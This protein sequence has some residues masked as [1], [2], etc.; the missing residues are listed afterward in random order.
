MRRDVNRRGFTLIELLVVMGIVLVLAGMLLT[1]ISAA[2]KYVARART[3]A[4]IDSLGL[5]LGAY[6][7]EFGSFPPGGLDS[8]EDGDCDDGGENTGAG[9]PGNTV[10]LMKLRAVCEELQF[11]NALGVVERTVGPYYSPN[12]VNIKKGGVHDVFGNPLRYLADG[13]RQKI[14]PT[15]GKPFIG[16]VYERTY[17][18]W[19]IA[20]DRKHD[21]ENNN[22]DDNND[23]KVDDARELENDIGSW[24]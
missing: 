14:D 18:I 20:E 5:A 1:G 21:P 8:N 12:K 22:L 15:T 13:R 11:K 23:G 4:M 7:E 17:V 10:D 16:R 6:K 2:K 19:S 3:K 24:N 9:E